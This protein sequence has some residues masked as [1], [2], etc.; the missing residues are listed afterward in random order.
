M[1]DSGLVAQ[2]L[3]RCARMGAEAPE[4]AVAWTGGDLERRVHALLR[5]GAMHRNARPDLGLAEGA[6]IASWVVAAVA[7]TPW[8]HHQVEHLLNLPI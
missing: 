5:P 8:I 4:A 7:A 1:G 3:L 2:A 6:V